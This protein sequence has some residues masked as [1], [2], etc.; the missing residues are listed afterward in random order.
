MMMMM[1]GGFFDLVS[2]GLVWLG[3]FGWVGFVWVVLMLTDMNT[4]K[5]DI[6]YADWK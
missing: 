3:W 2:V 6:F 4:F 1:M 5:V